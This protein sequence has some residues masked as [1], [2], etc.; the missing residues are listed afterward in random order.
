MLITSPS[1]LLGFVFNVNNERERERERER[2]TKHVISNKYVC[3][4]EAIC[5][6]Q[7]CNL[8][9]KKNMNE[10]ACSFTHSFK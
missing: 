10:K 9:S 8:Q 4:C 2:H 3:I 7:K 5:L 1:S 6:G